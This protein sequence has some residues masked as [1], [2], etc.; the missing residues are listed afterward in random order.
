MVTAPAQAETARTAPVEALDEGDELAP[1][2]PTLQV[3]DE[4]LMDAQ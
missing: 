3:T 4:E 1:A 2:E